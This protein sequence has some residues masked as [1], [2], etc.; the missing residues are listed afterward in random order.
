M[1]GKTAFLALTFFAAAQSAA[2]QDKDKTPPKT[3]PSKT[4]PPV[5]L[6]APA[7]AAP[8]MMLAAP[9]RVDS[10]FI[11]AQVPSGGGGIRVS[12]DGRYVAINHPFAVVQFSNPSSATTILRGTMTSTLYRGTPPATPTISVRPAGANPT[13]P[14]MF[15]DMPRWSFAQYAARKA[16]IGN[17]S[18]GEMTQDTH[19]FANPLDSLMSYEYNG[20]MWIPRETIIVEV[21]TPYTLR[22]DFAIERDGMTHYYRAERTLRFDSYGRGVYSA[23]SRPTPPAPTPSRPSVEVRR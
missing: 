22:T 10:I 17:L 12:S 16:L 5:I 23:M 9:L 21:N 15:A 2:A 6:A 14:Q 13:V 19:R 4:P 20:A 18:A 1:N 11:S 8:A 7:A 3:D